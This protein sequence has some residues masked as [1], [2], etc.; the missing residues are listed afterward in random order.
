MLKV[1]AGVQRLSSFKNT[2]SNV[3]HSRGGGWALERRGT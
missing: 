1:C 3:K 2:H